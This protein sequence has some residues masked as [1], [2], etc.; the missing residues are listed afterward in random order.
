[1]VLYPGESGPMETTLGALLPH[2]FRG[3]FLDRWN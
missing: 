1:V 3:E 2:A